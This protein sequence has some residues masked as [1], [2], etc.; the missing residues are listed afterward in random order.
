MTKTSECLPTASNV[1]VFGEPA[2]PTWHFDPATMRYY[3][4]HRGVRAAFTA[5]PDPKTGDLVVTVAIGDP[6]MAFMRV[7]PAVVVAQQQAFPTAIALCQD[8]VEELIA[9]YLA[10]RMRRTNTCDSV[11]NN[12]TIR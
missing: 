2:R 8:A 11:D 10:P 5:E 6:P 12:D 3:T 1:S 9:D 4:T 7:F